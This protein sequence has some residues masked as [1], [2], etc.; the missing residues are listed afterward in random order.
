MQGAS[1]QRADKVAIVVHGCFVEH[2]DADAFCAKLHRDWPDIDIYITEMAWVPCPLPAHVDRL[3]P[4]TYDNKELDKIMKQH[5]KTEWDLKRA[6]DARMKDLK[7]QQRDKVRFQQ[8]GTQQ[9]QQAEPRKPLDEESKQR[10]E[11]LLLAPSPLD[12]LS[13]DCVSAEEAE[14]EKLEQE[15]KEQ[16]PTAEQ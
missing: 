7:K 9:Q 12:G 4:K 11:E 5:Q 2:E 14:A 6:N 13:V 15:A 8:Q 3:V 10:V 1:R 16:P